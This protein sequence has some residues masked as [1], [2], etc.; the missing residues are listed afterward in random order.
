V[1]TWWISA[2]DQG[3]TRDAEGNLL[4]MS[5]LIKDVVHHCNPGSLF[6]STSFGLSCSVPIHGVVALEGP[7]P[8]TP[9]QLLGGCH[10][11]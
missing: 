7:F 1:H 4:T 8:A 5:T 11:G 9:V 6:G 10:A 3:T 2:K